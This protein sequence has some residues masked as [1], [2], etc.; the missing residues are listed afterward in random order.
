MYRFLNKDGEWVET[1][2]ERFKEKSEQTG[3]G[4]AK[5]GV[6]EG[7]KILVLA[8][9]CPQALGIDYAAYMNRAVTVPLMLNIST[10]NLKNVLVQTKP[11]VVIFEDARQWPAVKEA[12][13]A[14]PSLHPLKILSIET[15][16]VQEANRD[17]VI[18]LDD[19]IDVP[20]S[21]E[22]RA[23]VDSR[24]EAGTP[25]DEAM[26]IFTSGTQ[27][28]FRGVVICHKQFNAC[29]EMYDHRLSYLKDDTVSL[30]A[31]P[32]SHIFERTW[33]YF[34]FYK[35]V[36]VGFCKDLKDIHK[37]I[38]EVD[39][40][41]MC[42]V[43]HFWEEI[44]KDC[45]KYINSLSW[46]KRQMVSRALFIG[47]VRN[48]H[49][50]RL[51]LKVPKLLESEY[52]LWNRKLFS[53]LRKAIGIT[54]PIVFPTAAATLNEQILIF[55]RKCGFN[56]AL[57]YGLTE[58]TA[59][60]AAFPEVGYNVGTVGKALKNTELKISNIGE[61][62]IKSPTIMKGY[63]NDPEATRKI[64]DSDGFLHTGDRGYL[65]PTGDLVL[66]G[67]IKDMYRTSEGD[68]FS[69]QQIETVMLQNCYIEQIAVVGDNKEYLIALI[70]PALAALRETVKSRGYIFPGDAELLR[71]AEAKQLIREEISKIE[72][73]IGSSFRIH[74][75]AII[76]QPFTPE[77]GELTATG[78]LRRNIIM[79][80]YER[81][82]DSL[83]PADESSFTALSSP[84][85]KK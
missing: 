50:K 29:V 84:H 10:E 15:D 70:Y 35:G 60:V 65:T 11:A 24:T 6:K 17:D 51:G 75:I 63:F 25:D 78:K 59:T 36:F 30:S 69:P 27:S 72:T 41:V 82:I 79:A 47:K 48:L 8:G 83:Y 40:N 18:W 33:S 80:H 38:S 3:L 64:I 81:T 12:L 71:S 57:G 32:L 68:W 13:E 55:F 44:Y 61:I 73:A 19:L 34:C 37:V 2:W 52:Q 5:L 4:F 58:A 85:R 74:N 16:G 26:I 22:I 20:Y 9:N 1:S 42:C 7:D 45:L 76:T 43:P 62:L 28:R 67:R 46:A 53:K 66:S 21:P 23:L 14:V 49:Y 54:R 56:I 39:P 31:L 77:N